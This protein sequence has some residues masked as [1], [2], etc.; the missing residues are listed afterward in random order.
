M[1]FIPTRNRPDAIRELIHSME[2]AGS[3]PE[4]AVMIDGPLEPY[5]E[6]RWPVNWHIH[7][8]STHL[9]LCG[10]MNALFKLYPNEKSYGFITDHGSGCWRLEKCTLQ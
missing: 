9:E 1:W 3:V 6:I 2:S 8:D 5:E 4:C 7:N 10:A